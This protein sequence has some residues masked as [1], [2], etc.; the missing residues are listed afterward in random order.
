M[1]KVYGERWKGVE[2]NL[3]Q[4]GQGCVVSVID[5]S[6]Q[7]E[8]TFALKRVT[9]PKRRDRF[10]AEVEAIKRLDHANIVKLIDHSA[11]EADVDSHKQFLVMPVAEGGDLDKPGR[12]RLYAGDIDATLVVAIQI[13]DA[14]AYAH[15]AGV[16]H[17][18]IKPANILC[19]GDGHEVWVS[20]FGICL[21]DEA[22]RA[23]EEHEVVGPWAF[24]APEL[25]SGGQ[26]DVTPACDVYSLGKLIYYLLSDGLVFPRE[27]LHEPQYQAPLMHSE[28]GRLLLNL[29]LQM[30]CPVDRRIATMAEVRSRL[31]VIKD[32]DK[33]G[34]ASPLSNGIRDQIERFRTEAHGQQ[35]ARDFNVRNRERELQ[36]LNMAVASVGRKIISELGAAAVAVHD[37]RVFRCT[38]DEHLWPNGEPAVRGMGRVDGFRSFGR[39]EL[40]LQRSDTGFETDDRLAIHICT[41]GRPAEVVVQPKGMPAPIVPGRDEALYLLPLYEQVTRGQAGTVHH[42]PVYLTR[43]DAIGQTFGRFKVAGL[44]SSGMHYYTAGWHEDRFSNTVAQV[45]SFKISAWPTN[46][47]AVT[48]FVAQAIEVFFANTLR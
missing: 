17:R 10:R 27:R 12:R 5:L 4:G 47:D 15:H 48:D 45:L 11:L 16:I 32:W 22:E 24:M 29:L 23:T 14:L 19:T 18:D 42:N 41:R 25:E 8:G 39:A 28:R 20:D 36:A 35:I 9:N 21:I 33:A 37:G 34:P 2:G 3:G 1:A 44:P 26:L 30:I 38:V 46:V 6:E 7:L 40:I 31:L 43:A 13:A